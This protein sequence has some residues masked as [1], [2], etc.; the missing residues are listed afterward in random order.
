[1]SHRCLFCFYSWDRNVPVRKLI[2]K[3]KWFKINTLALQGFVTLIIIRNWHYDRIAHSIG[4]LVLF[5]DH[6]FSSN[7]YLLNFSIFL[8]G[9]WRTTSTGPSGSLLIKVQA[10]RRL[11]PTTLTPSIS[12]S[13]SPGHTLSAGPPD[14]RHS[15]DEVNRHGHK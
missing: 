11:I 8:W 9:R 13:S 10:S 14:R 2:F 6:S 7:H 1:M 12:R 15:E 3:I 4:V 5:L